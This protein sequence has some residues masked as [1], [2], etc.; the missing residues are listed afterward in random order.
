M[1]NY[2]HRS[3][4]AHTLPCLGYGLLCGTLV[5]VVLFFFKL[6][7]E[8]LEHYSKIIY[9]AAQEH[10]GYAVLLFAG[11]ILLAS[12]MYL[13]HRRAPESKGGGIPRSEGILRG[14]LTF[15]WLRVLVGTVVGSFIS[16]FCGLPL[17]SEGP[18][19]LVGTALSHEVGNI[20]KDRE[21]WNR[22][23]MTGGACAGFAVA[24]GSPL[25][26][27]LFAL[28]EVHKR[29]TP[30]LVL[31]AS[32]SVGTATY[33]NFLLCELFDITPTLFAVGAVVDLDIGDTGYVLLLAL[34][35]AA[36][37]A[38]FD[39]AVAAA[40]GLLRRAGKKIPDYAKLLT[41]FLLTGVIGLFFIDGLYSGRGIILGI[42]DGGRALSYLFLL[43]LIRFVMMILTSTS[44]ATGGIFVP[45]LAIGALVGA[46]S[47][48]LLV[49][50]GMREELYGTVVLLAM[51]AFM[52]GTMRSPITAALFFIESTAAFTNL[53]YV[54][55]AVFVVYFAAELFNREPFYDAVLD[56]MVEEQNRGKTRKIVHYEV[57]V[58]E[59]AF[60]IGKAVRDILWPHSA[61]VTSIVRAEGAEKSMDNGGEKKMYAG[62]T[63]AL[64][65]QLC[66]EEEVKQCLY[67]L[68][69]RDHEIRET[70]AAEIL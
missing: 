7:A 50:V 4:L 59:G 63:I 36:S 61:I 60:V 10:I 18:S 49:S 27:I 11:L 52:G 28:E 8:K 30:M 54:A 57:V 12:A 44:G 1:K 14:L 32:V 48:K 45:T 43:L 68:V 64:K 25:T 58:S 62:D 38:I 20:S 41:V 24:T 13:L 37:V 47:G 21:A 66:D 39:S 29:F 40:R 2:R 35:V 6:A 15:R 53:F 51:V 16:F 19:V 70:E 26:A 65:I 23:V 33:M 17:G 69:G 9:G 31:I 67:N 42:L 5:G 3:Y 22:Y 56:D 34:L 55:L 46:I